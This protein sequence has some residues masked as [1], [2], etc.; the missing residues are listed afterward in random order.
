MKVIV[1]L[2]YGSC[3]SAKT[4]YPGKFQFLSYGQNCSWPL[5]I[6]NI[7]GMDWCLTWIFCIWVVI[8]QTKKH[9]RLVWSRPAASMVSAN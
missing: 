8:K 6:L 2:F 4:T 3:G 5:L 1:V 9:S 7:S